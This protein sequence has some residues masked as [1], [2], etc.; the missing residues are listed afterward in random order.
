LK[1]AAARFDPWLQRR[2]SWGAPALV[3]ASGA[4]VF[5]YALF[6]TSNLSYFTRE[7]A[8]TFFGYSLS[9]VHG[10]FLRYAEFYLP[11]IVAVGLVSGSRIVW[12]LAGALGFYYWSP[13]LLEHFPRSYLNDTKFLFYGAGWLVVTAALLLYWKFFWEHSF[14]H[15]ERLWLEP[16]TEGGFELKEVGSG[17]KVGAGFKPAPTKWVNWFAA[18]FAVFVLAAAA[19]S[20]LRW[21]KPSRPV[22]ESVETQVGARHALPL[23]KFEGSVADASGLSAVVNGSLVQVG[24]EILGYRIEEIQTHQVILSKEGKRYS[25]DDQG[26]LR[27]L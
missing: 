16:A 27:L 1:K 24:S 18:L 13:Y 5:S 26:N 15:E 22:S 25:L 10:K 4:F 8:R 2:F 12:F 17:S 6:E 21:P 11:L 19:F 9:P 3:L 23:L 14:W 20:Y 7:E